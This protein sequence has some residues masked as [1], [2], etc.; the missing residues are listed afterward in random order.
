M[1]FI[2]E[3]KEELEEKNLKIKTLEK[4][5]AVASLFN[6]IVEPIQRSDV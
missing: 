5:L 2:R 3:C 1:K 4:E 6:N